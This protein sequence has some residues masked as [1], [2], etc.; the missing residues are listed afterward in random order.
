MKIGAQN[1]YAP[2][3]RG[4]LYPAGSVTD[5]R[6]REKIASYKRDIAGAY[7]SVSPDSIDRSIPDGRH[8]VSTKIDG[9]QW[10]LLK[11]DDGVFL[12]SPNGKVITGIELTEEAED[13]LAGWSGLFAGE[14]YADL[15]PGRSRV[16][17]L[18]SVLGGG[19]SADT[20]RLHFAAF[21]LL[22]DGH[23][24]VSNAVDTAYTA[25]L[26]FSSRA[27]RIMGLMPGVQGDRIHPADFT[28]V[29]G[30]GDVF[31]FFQA[32]AIGSDAEGI[33]VRCDDGRAFKIKPIVSID[34][35]VVGYTGS[36]SGIRELLLGLIDDDGSVHLIGRVDTGFSR[37]ERT[38]IAETLAPLACGSEINLTSRSGMPYTWVRPEVVVEI[39]CHELLTVRT[40]GDPIRRHCLTYSGDTGW[41]TLGKRPSISLRD[42]VFV[43]IRTD[44]SVNPTD[45]RWSQVTDLAPV[46]VT[47]SA[48]T[49]LPASEIVRREVYAKRAKSGGMAVRKLVVWKSNKDAL[50]PGYPAYAVMFTD[51]SPS[52]REPI[53]TE[54]RT[55]CTVER[56]MRIA[57][58]WLDSRTGRGWECVVSTGVKS[59]DLE[60]AGA[61]M[62]CS[63]SDEL[64][65]VRGNCS[66]TLGISFARSTSPTF[67]IVRR[68]LDGLQDIGEL[69]VTPDNS[70]RESWF[71]LRITGGI[72]EHYRRI[73]NLLS[74]VRRW[75][76]LEISLDGEPLDKYVVD[77]LINRIEEIRKCWMSRKSSGPA[78]CMRTSA[79]G[80][81]CLSIIPSER[82]LI[83]AY[84]NEPQWY[85]VGRFD[86]RA[87]TVDKLYLVA[88][89]DRRK[90]GLLDCCPHFEKSRIVEAIGGLPDTISPDD[91]GYRVLFK[92][93]DRTPAWV[94]PEDAPIPPML[95]ERGISG[96]ERS[97]DRHGVHIGVGNP[98]GGGS[99]ELR[100]SR[101]PASTY[102]DICGQDEA[103][104]AVRD[105][106]ELPMRHASLFA[107]IGAPSKPGGV[108]LAGP[109]GTGKTLLARAVAGECGAHLEVV[110]GP[111][112]LNPYVGATEQ[113][114][115]EVFGR[116]SKRAPS[117]ILFDELD[118]IA[119]S[120]STAD[121]Q[122]QR[123]VVAQLLTLLD[124]LESRSG[125]YALATTNRPGS[126]DPALRRPGRFDRV[127]W[128]KLPDERGRKAIL[129]RYIEP[130]RLDPSIDRDILASELAALT[131]GASGADIEY[132]CHTAARV[133]VKQ[134]VLSDMVPDTM[135]VTRRH[136]EEALGTMG[137]GSGASGA[138]IP[139]VAS[140]AGHLQGE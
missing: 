25:E 13:I 99:S 90:N 87:V 21:D 12:V 26:P 27:E 6:L 60:S 34:A 128:M 140:I 22:V 132:L 51:Y 17:D 43:R 52:R 96:R 131:D 91:A 115:R 89:L 81:R 124:G 97:Q 77:D 14:L 130:L 54:L 114:L 55:A 116:A 66:H 62:N 82:F 123:S 8:V 67:P 53:E 134:A 3:G 84:I 41:S 135:V 126:I 63:H 40:D 107:E 29:D 80:C 133:C 122:H 137:Y 72:V 95:A 101:I 59:V 119:P 19:P 2:L 33:V 15:S 39:T 56:I 78:G 49:P 61:D 88:Q 92:R 111:E 35:A 94:W 86:G 103:V 102:A 48:A 104:E 36:D 83:G 38:E 125:I 139:A 46:V 58:A 127:V 69:E 45:V 57:D 47:A 105:M 75:K 112:L 76:S 108:I 31:S 16:Y 73:T 118:S 50:D 106:I 120:R 93:E 44:K 5:P 18:H 42:A 11:D 79:L 28:F 65:A 30:H 10:F 9:E 37:S 110:S 129:A 71:E 24:D 23:V 7:T 1:R 98:S 64:P 74:L 85:A 121:A 70:G 100:M 113:A 138:V 32:R 20:D 68:R 109:P 117:I 136:F 4:R